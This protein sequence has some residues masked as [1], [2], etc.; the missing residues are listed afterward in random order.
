M[1]TYKKSST[2][3]RT[4]KIYRGAGK[5]N[6]LGKPLIPCN[7]KKVT[8]YY[9]D[10]FCSTGDEDTGTHV[11]C[12]IMDDDFLQY[13]LKE[14]NDL[15]TPRGNSFPGLVAGDSWCVCALRWMQAYRAGKAPR[16][17]LESTDMRALKFI[18]RKIL[19][20]NSHK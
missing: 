3:K 11:V 8:G 10:G 17:V 15:I 12:G 6:V 1:R 19:L 13:M 2:R 18:P 7:K 5:V 9:R 14:D 4:R 16:V 20:Q